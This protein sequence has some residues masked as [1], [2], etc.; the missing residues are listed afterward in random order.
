VLDPRD[1]SALNYAVTKRVVI[2]R[3]VAPLLLARPTPLVAA[4]LLTASACSARDLCLVGTQRVL[5][6]GSLIMVMRS[7]TDALLPEVPDRVRAVA[8]VAGWRL[9]PVAEGTRITYARSHFP[10]TH[11]R[12][13]SV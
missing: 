9:T 10:R 6:D 4:A 3:Q 5:A 8:A 13:L 2:T 7:V 12:I 1:Y 11:D